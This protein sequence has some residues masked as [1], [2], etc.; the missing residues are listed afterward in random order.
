MKMRIALGRCYFHLWLSLFYCPVF[1][2]FKTFNPTLRSQ[3]AVHSTFNGTPIVTAHS[4]MATTINVVERPHML[5]DI[6]V[7]AQRLSAALP[8]DDWDLEAHRRRLERQPNGIF[9][10]VSGSTLDG[11]AERAQLIVDHP[12]PLR[13]HGTN[14]EDVMRANDMPSGWWARLCHW[15]CWCFGRRRNES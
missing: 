9:D 10:L 7:H 8:P 14:K 12:Q 15:W 2:P 6:V 5:S 13:S 1:N 4:G 11:D 3:L